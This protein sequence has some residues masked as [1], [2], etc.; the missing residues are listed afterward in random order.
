MQPCLQFQRV[1]SH[2]QR[3]SQDPWLRV[4]QAH[5]L[6][7]ET[8]RPVWLTKAGVKPTSLSSRAMLPPW[9]HCPAV[10][11]RTSTETSTWTTKYPTLRLSLALSAPWGSVTAAPTL[12]T[13]EAWV[14]R[15]PGTLFHQTE[16]GKMA[17]PHGPGWGTWILVSFSEAKQTDYAYLFPATSR[18]WSSVAC[19]TSAGIRVSLLSRTQNTVR[20]QHPPICNRE[21]NTPCFQVLGGKWWWAC[22]SNGKKWCIRLCPMIL[23]LTDDQL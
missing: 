12:E 20:L 18:T 2:W 6:D 3:A 8:V 4:I 13:S 22:L 23:S 11:G 14:V 21:E 7:E 16:R 17:R 19:D 9:H 15:L 1:Q 5:F 10:L